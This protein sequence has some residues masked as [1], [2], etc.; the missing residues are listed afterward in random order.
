ME[1]FGKR[2]LG[3]T[4]AVCRRSPQLALDKQ[5]ENTLKQIP[6]TMAPSQPPLPKH[7][8]LAKESYVRFPSFQNA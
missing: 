6:N 5:F 7:Q 8:W 4:S 3:G 1:S 2:I